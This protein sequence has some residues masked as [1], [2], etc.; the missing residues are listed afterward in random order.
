M[1]SFKN[2][3]LFGLTFGG[4]PADGTE[5]PIACK[6]AV[7]SN[8]NSPGQSRPIATYKRST[9]RNMRCTRASSDFGETF[10]HASHHNTVCVADDDPTY[11]FEPGFYRVEKT[12]SP[13]PQVVGELVTTKQ[14]K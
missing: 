8:Q 2:L 1:C 5:L 10:V 13:R 14:T 12:P 3:A 9:L 6:S 7:S 4:V 11:M